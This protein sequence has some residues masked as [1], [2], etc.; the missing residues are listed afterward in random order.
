MQN[1]ETPPS[2]R[3]KC[4]RVKVPACQSSELYPLRL[5][6]ARLSPE[7]SL[8]ENRKETD[9]LLWK[10]TATELSIRGEECDF[11]IISYYRIIVPY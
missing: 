2:K 6:R 7:L 4:F 9:G 3:I 1:A 8:L 10:Y 11:K 5:G